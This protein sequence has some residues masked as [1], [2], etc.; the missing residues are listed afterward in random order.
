MHS[1]EGHILAIRHLGETARSTEQLQWLAE[2]QT[3]AEAAHELTL[4][5]TLIKAVGMQQ[6]RIWELKKLGYLDDATYDK[7]SSATDTAK[8]VTAVVGETVVSVGRLL[9]LQVGIG[10]DPTVVTPKQARA[11]A[12]AVVKHGIDRHLASIQG[13][14]PQSLKDVFDEE[15][16]R[17]ER[18]KQSALAGR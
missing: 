17:L 12:E 13:L 5:R 2:P 16:E 6:D 15:A 10:N 3:L 11:L 9:K 8:L 14:V 4:A 7:L 18:A 1:A